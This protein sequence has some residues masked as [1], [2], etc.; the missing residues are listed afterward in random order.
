MLYPWLDWQRASLSAWLDAARVATAAT[1]LEP[2]LGPPRELLAR[3]LDAGAA[4]E[5]PLEAAV[6][7]DVPF[8]VVCETVVESPFVRLV[9][10]RRPE[11]RRQRLLLLTL[12]SGYSTAVLSPLVAAL[13]AAGEVVAT[14]WIDARL[15]P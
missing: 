12:H 6:R 9:R 3:T 1:P 2:L 5:R 10:V 7:R 4:A 13:A 15:V 14:D 11:A 8:P